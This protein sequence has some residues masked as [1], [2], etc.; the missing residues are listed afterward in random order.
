MSDIEAVLYAGCLPAE[1]GPHSPRARLEFVE[2][3]RGGSV[4]FELGEVDRGHFLPGHGRV[5][6]L[7]GSIDGAAN[8]GEDPLGVQQGHIG[9]ADLDTEGGG[10]QGPPPA[11]RLQGVGLERPGRGALGQAVTQQ[12]P[13]HVGGLRPHPPV[14]TLDHQPVE[15][16]Q[17]PEQAFGGHR[18]PKGLGLVIVGEI[19]GDAYG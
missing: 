6:G 3:G 7:E 12:P 15:V 4:L 17:R 19:V 8:R 18:D 2:E 10:A 13:H 9:E 11:P 16:D 1:P 5:V 14:P